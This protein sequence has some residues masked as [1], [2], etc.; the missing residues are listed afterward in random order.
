MHVE[1]LRLHG[2]GI[3][4][5]AVFNRRRLPELDAI[6]KNALNW[7]FKTFGLDY[8]G[9]WIPAFNSPAIKLA[10]RLGMTYDGVLRRVMVYNG[11]PTDALVYS[12]A[13][14]A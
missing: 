6:L 13:R 1:A 12:I 14:G 7:L 8:I 2:C 4:H 5:I 3:V 9:S 11:K 10:V